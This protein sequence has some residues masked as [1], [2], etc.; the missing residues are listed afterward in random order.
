MAQINV[1]DIGRVTEILGVLRKHGFGRL[2]IQAGLGRYMP[3]DDATQGDKA[4][5]T[6]RVR[7]ALAELGPTYV[8][9]GQILSVRPDIVPARLAEE[10]QQLQ[11]R[12]PPVDYPA[13]K[14]VVEDDLH[15]PIG[16]SFASFEERAMASASIAQVHRATL[17]DGTPVAVKVRRPDIVDRVQADLRILYT[18]AR[19]VEG[20]LSLP[21]IYTPAAIVSEFDAALNQELDFFQ[22]ANSCERFRSSIREKLPD[23]V[24]PRVYRGHSGR[25]VLTLELIEGRAF[26]SIEPSDP[27][28]HDLARKLIEA[29]YTQVFDT[30][31]FHG[32]PHPGNLI[33]LP[34]GRLGYLDFGLVGTI[35][36][37]MQQVVSSI[38]MSM[39]FKDA[40]GLVMAFTR[41]G[42]SRGRLDLRALKAEIEQEMAKIHGASLTEMTQSANLMNYIEIITRHGLVMPKEYAVLARTTNLVFGISRKLL[43]DCDIVAEVRPL[44]E[45]LVTQQLAPDHMA[46]EA[47]KMFLAAR[48]GVAQLPLQATQLLADLEAGRVQIN[49]TNP[50]QDALLTEIRQAGLRIAMAMCVLALSTA[51]AIMLS[52]AETRV[53]GLKLVPMLGVL[54]I[55]GSSVLWAMLVAH[56][57]LA[58]LFSL[59]ATRRGLGGL[60]RFFLARRGPPRG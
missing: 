18:L 23:V 10:L 42:A 56:S 25:R 5:W 7:E 58:G 34:D 11:D 53:L 2:I 8:K 54:T 57:Q 22:E 31:L 39:V 21:G 41:A 1:T 16:E 51:G 33:V 43:P 47:A 46:A 17:A 59:D 44:A 37:E 40:D 50:D 55:I 35:S 24:V 15:A 3:E 13:I 6:V 52:A 38:F 9:L 45:R 32:D 29:S 36:A 12:V 49:T 4:H 27:L 19:L 28:A 60:F 20:R 30:G 26:H 14:A 48:T